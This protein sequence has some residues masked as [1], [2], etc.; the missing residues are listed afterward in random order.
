MSSNCNTSEHAGLSDEAVEVYNI[1][2]SSLPVKFYIYTLTMC[3][4]CRD[5]VEWG[6]EQEQLAEAKVRENSASVMSAEDTG[7]KNTLC[8]VCIWRTVPVM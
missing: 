3:T 4:S 8:Y 7:I 6:C 1:I 2:M 5:N